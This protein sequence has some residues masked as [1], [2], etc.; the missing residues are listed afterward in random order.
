MMAFSQYRNNRT[1]HLGK[2]HGKC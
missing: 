2:W 1:K